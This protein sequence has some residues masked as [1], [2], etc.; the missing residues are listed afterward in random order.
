MLNMQVLMVSVWRSAL[1][2]IIEYPDIQNHEWLVDDSEVKI[3]CMTC[4]PAPEEVLS[5]LSCNCK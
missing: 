2:A 1:T 3:A 5:L 4:Q